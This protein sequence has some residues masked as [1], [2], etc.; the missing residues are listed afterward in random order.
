ALAGGALGVAIAALAVRA[1]TALA[2]S[3][4][5]RMAEVDVDLRV[6]VFTAAISLLSALAFGAFPAL[7]Y[8]RGDLSAVLEEGGARGGTAG[9]DR[10]R[11]RNGLVVAQVSLALV[12]LVG[13]GLM[14]RS[15]LALLAV[16]P[17]F[18]GEGVL[19]VR[20]TVPPGEV[21]EPAAVANL[22]RQL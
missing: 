14:L 21:A 10:H 16:D 20:L 12:L 15:F 1:T 13:S 11:V 19:T 5:P 4:L 9:R 8:G 2:P 7:R 3:D 6:L 18:R 22:Y 17:G